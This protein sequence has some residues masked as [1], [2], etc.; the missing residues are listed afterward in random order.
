MRYASAGLIVTLF[1]TAAAAQKSESGAFEDM[2]NAERAFVQVA[3]EKNW[4]EAFLEYFIEGI[5]GFEGE[6]IKADLR[7]RPDP[8]KG[9][10]FWWEPRYGD[11][12]ASGDL[13]WLT[14]PVRIVPPDAKERKPRYSNY[15]SFWKRQDGGQFK[16]I[17]DVGVN[18][19][20]AVPFPPGVTRVPTSDRYRGPDG[21]DAAKASLLEAD[22]ALTNALTSMRQAEAYDA[23]MAPSAR[24]HRNGVMPLAE[25]NASLAWLKSQPA[26]SAGE[27]KFAEAARSGDLGHTWGSYSMPKPGSDTV[28]SGHYVRAW[29]RDGSG[30]WRMT[31]D[32]LQ[33]KGPS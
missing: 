8:P 6:D 7:K 11:I 1:V 4:K 25:K 16:V 28:E 9:L 33:P 15:A 13:G 10:E 24:F 27:T 12:A 29:V 20:D 2:V 3:Q 18:V 14:G 32:V 5:R 22:R 19:P 31:L 23:A 17:L 21:A 30:R 26:W